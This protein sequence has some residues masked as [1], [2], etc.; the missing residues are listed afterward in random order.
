MYAFRHGLARDLGV[1]AANKV[2]IFWPNQGDRGTH[3]NVSGAGLTAASD[4]VAEATALIEFLATDESQRWY[5]ETNNEYP[6]RDDIEPSKLLKSW[7]EFK[8]DKVDVTELGRR[9]SEAVMAMDRAGW[10]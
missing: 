4:N 6:V 7:G 9:N 5:A 3:I 1:D 2:A 10:K 8:A